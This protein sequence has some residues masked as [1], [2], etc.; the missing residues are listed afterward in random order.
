MTNLGV[1]NFVGHGLCGEL[2][3]VHVCTEL[4]QALH[5]ER[6]TRS[7]TE[8]TLSALLPECREGLARRGGKR[9]NLIVARR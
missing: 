5:H 6:E 3:N 8:L 2:Q 9:A 1:A 4:E 7:R